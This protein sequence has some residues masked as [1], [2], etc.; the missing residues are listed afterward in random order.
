MT[1]TEAHSTREQASHE[2]VAADQPL[3]RARVTPGYLLRRRPAAIVPALEHAAQ[4]GCL[5][6]RLPTPVVAP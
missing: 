1:A 3:A 5:K 2:L 6:V 4:A